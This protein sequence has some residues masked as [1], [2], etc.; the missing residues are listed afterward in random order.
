V[1]ARSR[2]LRPGPVAAAH[3]GIDVGRAGLAANLLFRGYERSDLAIDHHVFIL[4]RIKQPVDRGLPA[5][6]A[7]ERGIRATAGTAFVIV[8]VFSIFARLSRLDM[9][10]LGV[11]LDV[12]ALLATRVVRAVPLPWTMKL[13]GRRS[14]YLPRS[15][16]WLARLRHDAA[17]LPAAESA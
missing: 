10:R 16:R 13:L 8:A 14:W 1:R 5:Q 4:S 9:K 15:L 6:L 3:R 2:S 12:A 11:G 17:S 7:V